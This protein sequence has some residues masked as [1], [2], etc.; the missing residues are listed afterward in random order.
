HNK[1]VQRSMQNAPLSHDSLLQAA[2][3]VAGAA[4]PRR[5]LDA[6]LGAQGF[7]HVPVMIMDPAEFPADKGDIESYVMDKI[8]T[9]CAY[10]VGAALGLL[11]TFEHYKDRLHVGYSLEQDMFGTT[12]PQVAIYPANH[13]KADSLPPQHYKPAQ[14]GIV[15]APGPGVT[16]EFDLRTALN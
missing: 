1:I 2:P 9:R 5:I 7:N 10:T 13:I 4:D 11:N 14:A 3:D 8:R 6:M 12:G 15:F 16:A